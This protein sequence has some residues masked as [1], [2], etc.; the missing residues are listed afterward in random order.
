MSMT[1]EKL[2][3]SMALLTV[4]VPADEFVKA[5]V[6]A[7]NKEKGKFQMPG[8]RKGKVPMAYMEKVYGPEIFYEDAANDLINT[9]YPKE[10][11]ECDLEIVSRPEIDIS[12]I[13]KGKDFIFTAKVALKP[14]V[15]LGEYKGIEIEKADVTVT[16]EEVEERIQKDLKDN[17]RKQDVA[18]RP[19]KDGD[20]ALINFE[21]FIDDEPFDG[22]KGEKYTLKLGSHSFIDTFEDQIVGKN[23][24]DKFDV[25][26][27]F[28]EDYQAEELKGKPAVFKV[29]LLGLKEDIVP[30][31]TDE[32]VD[33]ISEFEKVDDYRADI[34]KTL[35]LKKQ[36]EAE[37]NKENKCI[38]KLVEASEIDIPEPMIDSQT[39]RMI[40]DFEMRLQY[41][42][43]NLEQ[44]FSITKQTKEDM[45][46]QLKP[47]AIDQI[48]SRLVLEEV[49]KAE[50][51]EATE[52]EIDQTFK[53]MSEQYG[54]EV[55][56]I[57]SF[58][59]EKELE[60]MKKDI[61]VQKAAKVLTE[62]AKEV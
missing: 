29:E 42:G 30:E 7:Y 58:T 24:G 56:Q 46:E 28:P 40:D 22:G 48:K 2:E 12:Q 8:F 38:E 25:N 23:I 13:E 44:Y 17:A 35:E 5:T 47:Q 3:G 26:V 1:S 32:F 10:V 16:D 57:K 61:A 4:T 52:E 50:N 9:Y 19:A 54:I 59:G 60:S 27:T 18:D 45:K 55:D 15:K 11:E 51:I 43:L 62:N 37:K 41:Q 33:E 36:D 53:D 49:A 21:G 14:P 39:E 31:L 34:R 20:E 6:K